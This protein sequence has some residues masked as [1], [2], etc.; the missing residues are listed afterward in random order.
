MR[1]FVFACLAVLCF[2][3]CG[4]PASEESEPLTPTL[5]PLRREREFTVTN[6]KVP[7][8]TRVRFLLGL[9]GC[10]VMSYGRGEA[11][12]NNGSFELPFDATVER[13]VDLFLK[14]D[15]GHHF[16]CDLQDEILRLSD[17]T[18]TVGAVIDASA[19]DSTSMGCWLFGTE[20]TSQ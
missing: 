6:L 9:V 14:V 10:G 18:P 16:E 3:V 5:S 20:H 19:A 12:V 4:P 15:D 1:F 11:V 8:G 7:D 13:P 2:A 17:V